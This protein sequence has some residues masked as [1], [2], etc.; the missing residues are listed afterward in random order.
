[1]PE[2]DDDSGFCR[3]LRTHGVTLTSCPK[4]AHKIRCSAGDFVCRMQLNL[5][6][7]SDEQ[8]EDLKVEF[9]NVFMA[10][11]RS[12]LSNMETVERL[13]DDSQENDHIVDAACPPLAALLLMVR[14]LQGEEFK[15]RKFGEKPL[16]SGSTPKCATA[17][18]WPFG[19][20]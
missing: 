19:L 17:F 14:C 1:M 9:G 2:L 5:E 20:L 15:D 13:P 11:M 8:L 6:L 16:K 10:N 3:T 12:M 18:I 7:L 4:S